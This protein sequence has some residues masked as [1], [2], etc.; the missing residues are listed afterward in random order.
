MVF[1]TSGT[2]TVSYQFSDNQSS[3]VKDVTE[4]KRIITCDKLLS[5]DSS[6]NSLKISKVHDK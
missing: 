5:L 6:I 4:Y 3:F 2:I 1:I